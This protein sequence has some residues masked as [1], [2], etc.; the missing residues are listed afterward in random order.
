MTIKSVYRS[1]GDTFFYYKH[2]VNNMKL[3][4]IFKY[5]HAAQCLWKVANKNVI[6]IFLSLLPSWPLLVPCKL[7]VGSLTIFIRIENHV[8]FF[9]FS[10]KYATEISPPL[11]FSEKSFLYR[12]FHRTGFY[13]NIF[14]KLSFFL[15]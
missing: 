10:Q 13:L 4:K 1:R 15:S 6:S 2:W 9:R 7:Y 5:F 8:V 14:S 12:T 3:L 11:I